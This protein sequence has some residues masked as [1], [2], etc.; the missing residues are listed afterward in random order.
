[1]STVQL[2]VW[3][4]GDVGPFRL[5]QSLVALESHL[6]D[7][8]E[9]DPSLLLE[10]LRIVGRQVQTDGG[11]IDLLGIDAQE[12]WVVVELKRARLPR[13]ALAQALDYASSIRRM[14]PDE[15]R[16]AI[17]RAIS[18]TA[19]QSEV[20]DRVDSQLSG[21]NGEREVV[22][23]LAGTGASPGLDR[24]VDFL[25]AHDLP[26][27]VVTFSVFNGPDGSQLLVR[28]IL[29]DE[30]GGRKD[31][32][33]TVPSRKTR[34]LDEIGAIAAR[35]GVKEAYDRLVAAAEDRGLYCR[36][37]VHTVM[38]TPASDHGRYLMLLNPREG[39]GLRYHYEAQC[40]AEFFGVDATVVARR[41]G[42]PGGDDRYLLADGWEKTVEEFEQFFHW[43]PDEVAIDEDRRADFKTV[44]RFAALVAVGEW[45]TYRELS[46]AATGRPSASMA[47][48]G[49]V[50]KND[51]SNAHR[52]LNHSGRVVGDEQPDSSGGRQERQELLVAEGV[53]FNDS[54]IADPSRFV[55]GEELLRRATAGVAF[56]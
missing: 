56:E 38:I 14:R 44:N 9:A 45:T 8:C 13:E 39:K 36:P 16:S 28:E 33:P 26:I 40:F 34:T 53:L 47:V 46:I 25:G 3:S 48:G 21:E 27:R 49:H 20:L 51:F 1:M 37:Y 32:V 6:E 22:I 4:I 24:M 17:I 5:G 29:D 18:K 54:G 31:G 50:R 43:L 30:D 7:W 10:G 52:V 15:L 12:R 35:A 2:G 55:T 19:A 23:V 11:P 42:G 41:L